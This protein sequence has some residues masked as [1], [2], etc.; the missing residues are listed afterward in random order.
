MTELAPELGEILGNVIF[1]DQTEVF[2][3]ERQTVRSD[4]GIHF[5]AKPLKKSC[6]TAGGQTRFVVYSPV[7]WLE[8]NE[9]LPAV[10]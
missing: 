2:K 4:C 7:S 10:C 3:P 1:S 8:G 6:V 5:D 9:G